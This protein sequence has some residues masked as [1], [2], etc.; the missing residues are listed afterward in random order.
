VKRR[1]ITTEDHG[2]IELR[3]LGDKQMIL[4]LKTRP[5]ATL[6]VDEIEILRDELDLFAKTI[7]K[8]QEG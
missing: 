1:F 3:S 2:T 5:T 4:D 6:N 8:Q 7:R